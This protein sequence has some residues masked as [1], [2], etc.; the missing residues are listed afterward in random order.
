MTTILYKW[1]EHGSL[2]SITA[3]C[4]QAEA[5]LRFGE[6][7]FC[8]QK[9]T[10]TSTSPTGQL[11]A[12]EHGSDISIG[13]GSDFA[14]VPAFLEVARKARDLDSHLSAAQ[15]AE[16]LA[17]TTLVNDKL[18]TATTYSTWVEP[19]G[20]AAF[21]QA[22]YSTSL[23]FPLNHVVP[24]IHR[25]EVVAQLG[26]VDAA[27]V[28]ADATAVLQSVADKLRVLGGPFFF[29]AKPTSL[30]ALLFGHLAFYKLSPV[31][32]PVLGGAVRNQLVLSTYVDRVLQKYWAVSAPPP[33][34]PAAV[35]AKW[36]EAAQGKSKPKKPEPTP[37]DLRFKRAG[38]LWM[39]GAAAACA[40][41][42]L[43][44][45]RYFEIMT[46]EDEDDEGGAMDDDEE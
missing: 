31:A 14:A 45:N 17:F 37:S 39:F 22:A 11:P 13:S 19:A 33:P 10:S 3:A 12:L 5:Y 16:L 1:P 30:D 44:G 21:R 35:G 23:P 6:T 36:S 18:N 43:L 2:P 34:P 25:R 38:Q 29:G 46:I 9:C 41:Y 40:A 20:F 4:V 26:A 24:W 7:D 27:T 8:A 28:Y 42:I 15:R 32:G